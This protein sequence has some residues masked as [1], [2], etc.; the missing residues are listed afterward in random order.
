M[1]AV[2]YPEIISSYKYAI[3]EVLSPFFSDGGVSALPSGPIDFYQANINFSMDAIT[4]AASS[5][6]G[7]ESSIIPRI[8]I[9]G[10]RS[11]RLSSRNCRNIIDQF[12][13]SEQHELKNTIFVSIPREGK[14]R[15]R[16]ET[17]TISESISALIVDTVWSQIYAVL[18]EKTDQL[19]VRNI[20]SMT[21][22]ATPLDVSDEDFYIL[23]GSMRSKVLT[24]RPRV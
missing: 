6:E 2:R 15:R 12:V 5:G 13:I 3:Q 22:D 4:Q 10:S 17:A 18:N 16:M 20:I 14:I 21:V 1:T 23:R 9:L 11:E 8:T 19:R 7:A 24:S